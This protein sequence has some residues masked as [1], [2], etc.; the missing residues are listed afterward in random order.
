MMIR[1]DKAFLGKKQF[2]ITH[3]EP[4][5]SAQERMERMQFIKHELYMI[6]RDIDSRKKER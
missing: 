5:L 3:H 1:K 6:F 4:K 2:V